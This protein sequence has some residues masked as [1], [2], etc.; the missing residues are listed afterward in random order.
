MVSRPSRPHPRWTPWAASTPRRSP[1]LRAQ[2]SFVPVSVSTDPSPPGMTACPHSVIARSPRV[3]GPVEW[4][5]RRLPLAG[6]LGRSPVDAGIAWTRPVGMGERAQCPHDQGRRPPSRADPRGGHRQ[7]LQL[8][9]VLRR[10]P[11]PR[12][13]PVGPAP[14]QP[15][16]AAPT[17]CSSS[18]S[19]RW[20]SCGSSCCS[21]SCT[22]PASCSPPTSWDRRSSGSRGSST[23]RSSWSSSGTCSPPSR[24][25]STP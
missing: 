12:H 25:A 7:G 3:H 2:A 5:P 20:P 18:F 6:R 24:P 15:A 22:R 10:L 13:P 8:G 21:T 9:D 16:P 14:T 11:R 23:C 1:R 4:L 17:S 19:T